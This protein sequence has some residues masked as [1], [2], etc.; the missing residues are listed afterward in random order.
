MKNPCKAACLHGLA[1]LLTF[2]AA[3]IAFG[4]ASG[5]PVSVEPS[6]PLWNV[7]PLGL[8]ATLGSPCAANED[9]N[10]SLL[11]GDPLLDS[12]PA[13]PGWV[14]SMEVSLIGPHVENRLSDTVTRASGATDTV[15]L[16]TA[17]LGF[18]AMPKVEIG[19][20]CGQAAG[21]LILSWRSLTADASQLFSPAQLPAFAPTGAAV[22]SRLD[23]Q[24]FDLDYASHEPLTVFGVDMKWR[25]GLQGMI[26]YSDSQ[27]AN[28]VLFQHT[29]DDLWAVGPHALVDFRR[30]IRDTGLDLFGR[31]EGAI[32]FGRIQQ[33]FVETVTMGGKMDSGETDQHIEAQL[34]TI[35]FQ[36]GV[37]WTPPWSQ[38]FHVTAGYLCE[39]FL[40][41]GT[42]GTPPAPPENL[43]LQGGFL[44]A[45]WNY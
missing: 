7:D 5:V 31:V 32:P 36:A 1:L 24:V 27:A 41:L 11:I 33:R 14:G 21:E 39:F 22:R 12:G 17:Q 6:P 4:Q 42:T 15:H 9:N 43:W 44:R 28:D 37:S 34:T 45:E 8:G 18:Q 29:T 2:A 25:A 26:Y 35:T 19:Y 23:L 13:T 40:Y 16:P 10:G 20:R 3:D 30:P 38:R